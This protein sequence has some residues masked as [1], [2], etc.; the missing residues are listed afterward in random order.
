MCRFGYNE[1]EFQ[2]TKDFLKGSLVLP[3]IKKPE[4][5]MEECKKEIRRIK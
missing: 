5:D 3:V 2:Y 1:L 4:L